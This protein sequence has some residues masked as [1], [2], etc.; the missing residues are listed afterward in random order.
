MLI[1]TNLTTNTMFWR[2]IS[3]NFV[4]WDPFIHPFFFFFYLFHHKLNFNWKTTRK[5]FRN[6]IFVHRRTY[7]I[8][9]KNGRMHEIDDHLDLIIEREIEYNHECKMLPNICNNTDN[10][11]WLQQNTNN[12]YCTQFLRDK[13]YIEDEYWIN[14]IR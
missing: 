2:R 8:T 13:I 5:A 7:L 10:L 12:K 11:N 1:Y 4:E 3:W 9:S 14:K 6:L